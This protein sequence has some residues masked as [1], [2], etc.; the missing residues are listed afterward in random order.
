M[1]V[2]SLQQKPDAVFT[3][4]VHNEIAAE[5]KAPPQVPEGGLAAEK[6]LGIVSHFPKI[7]GKSKAPHRM[8]AGQV[9]E[10]IKKYLYRK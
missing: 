6:L 7:Q 4:T 1:L 10:N 8:V 2:K 5:L 3:I 9:S